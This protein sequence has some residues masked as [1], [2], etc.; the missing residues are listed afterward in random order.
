MGEPVPDTQHLA[1]P[2]T[3]G[4][5]PHTT[6]HI[7]QTPQT[8][9]ARPSEGPAEAAPG[10][11]GGDA[12]T[13]ALQEKARLPLTPCPHPHRHT[14]SSTWHFV[15][16]VSG[17]CCHLMRISKAGRWL[18]CRF[19]PRSMPLSPGTQFPHLTLGC[20]TEPF[21]DYNGAGGRLRPSLCP[22]PSSHSS[23]GA[24]GRGPVPPLYKPPSQSRVGVPGPGAE[25]HRKA[26]GLD[27]FPF[28]LH[29]L[30]H[31]SWPGR[32]PVTF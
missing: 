23:T 19:P 6:H 7:P 10:E 1:P 29:A 13:G 21:K 24:D 28:P 14:P 17:L 11:A 31:R 2:L 27:V 16:D 30:S 3:E 15:R 22:F 5:A 4:Q 32:T 12:R 18:F 25:G 8:P 26:W 9:Q 20:L